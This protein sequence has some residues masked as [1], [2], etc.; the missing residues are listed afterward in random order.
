[1]FETI[2]IVMPLMLS[3]GPANLVSFALAAR[4]GLARI[5]A[6]QLGIVVM[7]AA[8]ALLLGFIATQITGQSRYAA[9]TMQLVGGGFIAY[10]GYRLTVRKTKNES[11]IPSPSF[12]GGMLVQ[13]LNP[14][15]PAVVLTV[16]AARPQQHLITTTIAIVCVGTVGLLMYG[17]LGTIF[18]R[19]ISTDKYLHA[20]DIAFGV[21]L[22]LVGLWIAV[23][24]IIQFLSS[25]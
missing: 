20:A 13:L 8:V 2:A 14:K 22:G 16:F 15:Y 1:M 25:A 7:Y 5:I 6:F 17:S 10:M 11:E 24:P 3:P 18:R 19:L 4:L 12:F 21:L 23:Q 9:A